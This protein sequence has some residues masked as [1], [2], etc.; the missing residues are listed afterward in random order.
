MGS[1]RPVRLVAWGDVAGTVDACDQWCGDLVWCDVLMVLFFVIGVVGVLLLAATAVL[2]GVLDFV[3][4]EG[5]LSG[6]SIAAFLTAFG[7]SGAIA[8]SLG[9]PLVAATGVGVVA[10]FGTGAAAGVIMSAASR[11]PTDA[12]PSMSDFTGREGTVVTDVPVGGFGEVSLNVGGQ[13]VKLA[14]RSNDGPIKAGSA[15]RVVA[16]LSPT[17]VL[18]ISSSLSTTLQ[19]GSRS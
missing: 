10:G 2:D 12:T 14:A 16:P 9:A 11:M 5:L 7:F 8:V 3:G 4:G 19:E 18:V 1:M 6:P 15:V 13:P 17:A